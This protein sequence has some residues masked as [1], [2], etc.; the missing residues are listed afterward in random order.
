METENHRLASAIRNRA[1]A[2]HKS[3]FLVAIADIPGSGK[4][5]VAKEMARLLNESLETKTA[6]LSMDGFH[7]L[8]AA[9]NQ[10]ADPKLAS[11]RRGA[12]WTFDLSRL[13]DFV[14]RLRV[15]ADGMPLATSSSHSWSA[16]DVL[17]APAFDHE[18]KDPVEDEITI[19]PDASIIILEGNYL[20]LDEPGWRDL[21]RLFDYCIFIDADL[22]DARAR[23]AKR[24][25]Q[26]GIEPTL[27]D[28]FRRVDSNDYLNALLIRSELLVPDMVL[29]SVP[30]SSVD[31]R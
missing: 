4:T 22:E 20:L 15:W 7:L 12:P 31:T 29:R 8:R 13:L 9:L 11:I 1:I 23:V 24:H 17:R 6:L 19:T 30:W 26:A 28:G 5:T 10:L 14:C 2:H 27:E 21:K 3:R 16:E 25:V 18:A